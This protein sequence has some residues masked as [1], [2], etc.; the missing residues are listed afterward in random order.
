VQAPRNG[1]VRWHAGRSGSG[2]L[3]AP[4]V[5][6]ATQVRVA[7]EQT[8]VT[9]P[10]CASDR[11]L[12]HTPTPAEVSQRGAAA[13]QWETSVA[14]QAAQ[15][16][17]GRQMGVEGPHSASEAQARQ[18]CAPPSHTGVVP[19]H[20]AF[21]RQPTQRPAVVLQTGVPPPHRVALVAEH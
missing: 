11:Q 4:S 19:L 16:P 5:V 3:G 1:P 9:P 18:A 7:G 10:Q 12:T 20:W 8:G 14:V 13:G 2:Q 21:D 6:Q 17:E 15:A